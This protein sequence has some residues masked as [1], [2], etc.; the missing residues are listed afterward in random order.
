MMILIRYQRVNQLHNMIPELIIH[1]DELT[2]LGT[3][4]RIGKKNIQ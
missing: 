3:N 2:T 4:G 1:D